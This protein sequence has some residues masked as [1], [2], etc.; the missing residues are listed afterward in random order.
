MLVHYIQTESAET[1]L[2]WV[3]DLFDVAYALRMNVF[4]SASREAVYECEI[5]FLHALK[6]DLEVFLRPVWDIV[7]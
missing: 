4:L 6:R 2:M 7:L 1:Y 5:T 3:S